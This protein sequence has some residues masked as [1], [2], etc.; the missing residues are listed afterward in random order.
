MK[1]I[2]TTIP[3]FADI[4]EKIYYTAA[5]LMTVKEYMPDQL[6]VNEDNKIP[7]AYIAAEGAFIQLLPKENPKVVINI[8]I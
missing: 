4:H 2:F 5:N 6:I 3:E 7:G 8:E 1:V